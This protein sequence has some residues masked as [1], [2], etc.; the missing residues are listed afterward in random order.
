ME[1]YAAAKGVIV[2][3]QTSNFDRNCTQNGSSSWNG[4]ILRHADKSVSWYIHFKNG[5][6]FITPKQVGD[7][8]QA[9]EFLGV[10]GSSGSSDWPHLHFEVHDSTDAV[11]DPFSGSCNATTSSSLWQTQQAYQIPS[12]NRLVIKNSTREYR[13]CPNLEITYEKDTFNIGDTLSLFA[14]MRDFSNGSSV[15]VRIKNA[16]GATTISFT[17]T[18]NGQ[19][20]ATAWQYW[21]WL[22][23]RSWTPGRYTWEYD[24]GGQMYKKT[25]FISGQVASAKEPLSQK[26]LSVTPN[27]A[28]GSLHVT[29]LNPNQT[30]TLRDILG[31]VCRLG[32]GNASLSLTGL[33]KG[34]YAVH[35]DGYKPERVLV[36]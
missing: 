30:F 29:G 36:E 31:A 34:V 10:S 5:A 14:Y 20:Y 16:T 23:T 2:R 13:A 21:W 33:A 12:V 9:G 15:A 18:N 27:P 4:I 25:F 35:A 11:I 7:S 1:V 6:S 32:T 3:K 19:S 24:L 22:I 17:N 8:V 28:S 26:Q